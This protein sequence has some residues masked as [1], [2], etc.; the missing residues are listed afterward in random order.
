MSQR[1]LRGKPFIFARYFST[2]SRRNDRESVVATDTSEPNN[3]TSCG[4]S[5]A[6]TLCLVEIVRAFI[7]QNDPVVAVPLDAPCPENNLLDGASINNSAPGGRRR[8][9]CDVT[10]V[11]SCD[12][13]VLTNRRHAGL[14]NKASVTL[15]RRIEKFR[16]NFM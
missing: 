7:R 10:R 6:T 13:V 9:A 14:A 5:H 3:A 16:R 12:S 4:N 8:D 11:T 2:E 15:I 1:I